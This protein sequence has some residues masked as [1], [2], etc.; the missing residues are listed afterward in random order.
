MTTEDKKYIAKV[1][2]DETG[3]GM[4]EASVAFETLIKAIKS[5]PH[6]PTDTGRKLNF[7]WELYDLRET[8]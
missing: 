8:N 2:R 6:L 5:A 4:M 7:S 3:C 1:I